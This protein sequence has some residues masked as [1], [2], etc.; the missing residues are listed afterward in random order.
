[1]H[2]PSW[3]GVVPAG[4]ALLLA[5]LAVGPQAARAKGDIQLP[6]DDPSH[7]GIIELGGNHI[8]NCGNILLHL[9]NRGLIGSAPGSRL[10]FAGAPSAQW[11]AGST[12]EYLYIA[13]LWVGALKNGEPHVTTAAFQIEWRP[14]KSELDR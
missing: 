3:S 6:P 1:M 10:P 14:G 9:D 11:P 7:Q 2:R 5:A 4:L 13:G 12:T 8:H